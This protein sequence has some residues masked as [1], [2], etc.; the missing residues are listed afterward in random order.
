MSFPGDIRACLRPVRSARRQGWPHP[1]SSSSS[2]HRCRHHPG[3]RRRTGRCRWYRNAWC[4]MVQSF[5]WCCFLVRIE[6]PEPGARGKGRRPLSG[7]RHRS[8]HSRPRAPRRHMTPSVPGRCVPERGVPGAGWRS[9]TCRAAT[10]G[11]PI[12]RRRRR[13]HGPAAAWTEGF[14]GWARKPE[15]GSKTDK[16]IPV[17]M[18][19]RSWMARCMAVGS[20]TGPTAL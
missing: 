11:I 4:R 10:Y 3:H 2:R 20:G 6:H 7:F 18:K 16:A 12:P 17:C 8:G 9:P 14:P 15:A 5:S 19:A 13:S 1:H